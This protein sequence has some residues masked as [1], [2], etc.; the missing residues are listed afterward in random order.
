MGRTKRYTE[1]EIRA[2]KSAR[3]R[4]IR[5]RRCD[6]LSDEDNERQRETRRKRDKLV[7]DKRRTK[8]QERE[9]TLSS[10]ERE[11]RNCRRRT[12]RASRKEADKPE[13]QE[14]SLSL[15]GP[16][17]DLSLV[18][19]DFRTPEVL[20]RD[21][22]RLEFKS[23]EQNPETAAVL[24]HLNRGVIRFSL[25]DL[26]CQSNLDAVCREVED[27]LLQ[28]DEMI[29]I[30]KRF[31]QADDPFISIMSCGSCGIKKP[32]KIDD[33]P[34]LS[35]LSLNC[36]RKVLLSSDVLKP[37]L[38]TDEQLELLNERKRMQ[39]IVIPMSDDVD[40]EVCV[41]D[42]LSVFQDDC[43]GTFHLHPELVS[44]ESEPSERVAYTYLC[45]SCCNH[46]NGVKN[47]KLCEEDEAQGKDW[48]I[49]PNSI[50]DGVDFGDF[51][52]IGLT[53]LQ[54]TERM[55]LS[56][57]RLY[58]RI[59]K[60]SPSYGSEPWHTTKLAGH[61]I[62]FHDNSTNVVTDIYRNVDDHFTD[63]S[64]SVRLQMVGKEK[65][66]IDDLIS[67]TFGCRRLVGRSYVL[68]QWM[69]VLDVINKHYFDGRFGSSVTKE[70]LEDKLR[71]VEAQLRS[72]ANY[73]IGERNVAFENS[74]GDD[75]AGV[76]SERVYDGEFPD[77]SLYA[78][79][80]EQVSTIGLLR[81]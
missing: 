75:T 25:D 79:S 59:V 62:L 72:N 13:E 1:D 47:R 52:R 29:D 6:V 23:F 67:R 9:K 38:Y 70:I 36:Y 26:S 49:P 44:W 15:P 39:K 21:A 80:R 64:S 32:G 22:S 19:P 74:I 66:E 68:Y 41:W 30:V 37:L 77:T 35:P 46:L 3:Q 17:V 60:F 78:V 28:P 7:V 5:K 58:N 11:A 56:K 42:V 51:R 33:G 16:D 40:E 65:E 50:A 63:I 14:N 76:R 24:W 54:P 61:H 31:E 53:P 48:R 81:A 2:R 69:K 57:V 45:S 4:A 71:S 27:E 55:I 10:S 8:R 43:Y 12:K 73:I 34:D 20:L 18:I